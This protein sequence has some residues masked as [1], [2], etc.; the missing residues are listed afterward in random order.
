[1]KPTPRELLEAAAGTRIP[2]NLNLYP[3]ILSTLTPFPSPTERGARGEGNWSTL[4]QTLRA[5]PALMILFVILA[6]ALLSGVAYAI[7][8]S[9]GYIPGVGIVEQGAPLRVLAEPVSQTREGITLTVDQAYLTPERAVLSYTVTGIPQEARPKGEAGFSCNPSTPTLLLSDGARLEINGGEGSGW[10]DGYRDTFFYPP[11]PT[12]EQSVT[13]LLPCLQAVAPAAAP[14]DWELTLRFVPAPPDLTIAPVLQI[15]TPPPT[16]TTPPAVS[17]AQSDTFMGLTYHLESVQNTG[18]GYLLETSLRWD[19]GLYADY[20]VG[21]GATLALRDATGKPLTLTWV[22]AQKYRMPIEAR[23]GLWGFSIAETDFTPPLT[24]TLPWVGA[25]LPLD[26]RPVFTFDPGPNPQ[27]GQEWTIDQTIDVLGQPARILSARF[28]TRADL[29]AYEWARFMPDD[30]Y[31]FEARLQAGSQFRAIAL[32]IESG[33][34]PNGSGTGGQPTERDENGIILAYPLMGGSITGPLVI[35]VP[36][37]DIRHDWQI[38]FDPRSLAGDST[39]T[40]TTSLNARLQIERVIPLD[41]G[42]Y[43]VGRALWDD[44]RFSDVGLGGWDARLLAPDGGEIPIEPAWL[45]EIGIP[46]PQPGQWAYRVH[47]LA[48]PNSLTL[49][50]SQAQIQLAQP[51][52]FTFQPDPAPQPGL[53]WRLDQTLDLLGHPVKIESARYVTQGDLHGFE[54]TITAPQQILHLPL[55]MESGIKDGFGGGGGSI[56]RDAAGKIK[57]MTLTSGQF[58]GEPILVTVR[59]LTLEG[60]WQTT[61]NPPPAP[62]GA[63][64]FYLPQAC[65]TLEGWKQASANPPA[66]PTSLAKTLLISRGAL[67]PAPSLFL[68]NLDGS[69]E[70]PLV[71]GSG[72]LSPDGQRLVYSDE[73]NRLV[74]WELAS[75][76]KTT[77][78]DGFTPRWSP[79][80]TRIAFSQ[81]TPKGQNIFVMNADGASLRQLTDQTGYL[82]IAGWAADGKSLLIQDG[83][84]IELLAAAD[85]SRRLLLQTQHNS[86]GSVTATLSPDGNWLAYLEKVPGRMTPGLYLKA[87]PAGEPRLLA[88]LEHWSVYNPLFSP[89]GNWLAFSVLNNDPPDRGA[90]TAIMNLQTCQVIPLPVDGELREWKP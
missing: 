84:N 86:Y 88:Q 49:S 33:F 74:I 42:Y 40:G 72:S 41:D 47:G 6:L 8:R 11:I 61:W 4:M 71:F 53:E 48:L 3:R 56:P 68:A 19:E 45:D 36:Y 15:A 65:L 75:G 29:S 1:M 37:V 78:S 23:R 66:P 60:S 44:P 21:T 64:P 35:N 16:P 58:T 70:Q 38:T 24:L 18:R 80:G 26:N 76:Q 32:S 52:T 34:S 67:S 57:T 7:G 79:D 17:L 90:S 28:I 25:N 81:T 51:Y 43:L 5:K 9:L 73:N 82:A 27:P 85:G 20:G 62:A 39:S 31:G 59:N 83:A 46:N 10:P 22:D 13:F 2:T 30:V 89:D 63:T 55:G 14:Q 50:M 12:T 77:L 69:Q 54:F 87:L